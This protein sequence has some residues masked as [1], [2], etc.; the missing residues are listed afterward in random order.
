MKPCIAE[1]ESAN[2]AVARTHSAEIS[3]KPAPAVAARS[4]SAVT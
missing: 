3:E 4:L 1:N 2:L